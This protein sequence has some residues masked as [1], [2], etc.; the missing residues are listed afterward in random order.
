MAAKSASVRAAGVRHDNAS[1]FGTAIWPRLWRRFGAQISFVTVTLLIVVGWSGRE[2]RSLTADHGIGYALG[3]V[4]LACMLGLLLYPLRKRV[5][6]LKALGPVRNWFRLH[7]TLGLSGTL[8]AL[9]HCNFRLGSFDSRVALFSALFVAGSGLV[10]RFL[11]AKVHHGLYG[12]KATLKE[13]LSQIS[14]T[15]PDGGSAAS[16][17]P[18]L[19]KRVKEFDRSVLVPTNNVVDGVKL[20]LRL[21]VVT[22]LEQRELMSFTREVLDF[23]ASYSK[24][25]ATHRKRL[26]RATRRYLSTHFRQVRRVAEFGVYERLFALW[27]AVHLPFFVLLVISVAVH[28][29]AVYTY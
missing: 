24:P 14:L 9:Y 20:L 5:R 21:S 17:V 1:P 2:A 27:H 29:W 16:F 23:E 10:G 19:M 26:V 15:G 7:M 11:Y 25:V 4:A 8:V 22:R 13:L 28:V 6:A 18:E 3:F 12:R